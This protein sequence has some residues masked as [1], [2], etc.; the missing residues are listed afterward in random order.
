MGEVQPHVP[1]LLQPALDALNLGSGATVVDATYGRGGHSGAIL[2][3]LGPAGRLIVM[4][5][6]PAAIEHARHRFGGDARVAIWHGS[7]ADLAEKARREGLAGRVDGLLVDLGVSSPQ[8]DQPDRGFSFREDGPLDMRMDPSSGE[9]ASDWLARV[10]ENEL[11]R[12][13]RDYGEERHARRIA[14]TIVRERTQQAITGTARLAAVVASAAGRSVDKLHP[15]TRTF[16]AIRI[17]INDELGALDRL[18]E[19][20]LEVLAPGGRFVVISFH[21]LE[22][23]RVKQAWVGLSRPPAASRRRPAAPS[24]RPHLR[25]VG[26]LVRPDERE[27]SLNPRARSARMRVAEKLPEVA[28]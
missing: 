7:F 26:K 25:L 21:S 20:G 8:L 16:Q 4:D 9:P 27:C 28:A 3:R 10:D 13:I 17:H 12:V 14:R 18:L 15:A 1:V 5:R 22:D 24:F 11:V 23:R 2:D 19:Q 6:D